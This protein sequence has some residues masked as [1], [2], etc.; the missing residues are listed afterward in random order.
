CW[1]RSRR[2]SLSPACAARSR[3]SWPPRSRRRGLSRCPWEGENVLVSVN[4]EPRELPAGSTVADLP[5][6]L[7]GAPAGRGVAIALDGVVVPR[8]AWSDTPLAEGARVEILAAV[9]GG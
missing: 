3:W 8:G 6:L 1:L 9:Q 7:P 4:G 2:R 5:D